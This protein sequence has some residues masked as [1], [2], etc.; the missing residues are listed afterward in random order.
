MQPIAQTMAVLQEIATTEPV[1][2][3]ALAFQEAGFELA[4]VGGPVRDAFLGKKLTDLDF[5]TSAL[6]EE[7]ERVL[8]PIAS[9]VWSVGQAFG[10]VGV[11]VGGETIEITTYRADTYVSD[12]RKPE[13]Q[14]GDTIEEDL[15]R[16]DFTI[17][18]LA[19][20]L[21]ELRLIDIGSGV[22]DLL[23]GRIMTPG[24]PETSFTD[25]PL[26]MLRAARFTSQLGF[27]VAPEVQAAM[28][29]LAPRLE[30]ISA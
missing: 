24:S 19:L 8:K 3:V 27:E 28:R 21:P 9:R 29:E 15:V 13:V 2:T 20:M 16:R 22:E 23:A 30:I 5:T 11:R 6:P 7:T 25:D 4:L 12:S 14:F 18:A 10:T 26:R 17:N 1:K